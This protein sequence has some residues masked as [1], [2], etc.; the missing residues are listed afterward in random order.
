M[1][2]FMAGAATERQLFGSRIATA[3]L[4]RVKFD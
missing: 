2:G 4:A 3:S 1:T